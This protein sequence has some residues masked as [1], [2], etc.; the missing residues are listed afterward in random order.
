MADGDGVQEFSIGVL[1]RE[2]RVTTRTIRY[3]EDE[4]LL[5]PERRGQKRVYGPRERVRLRLILRGKRLGFSIAEIREILDM[6]QSEPGEAGQ[7]RHLI[8][9]I[10]ERRAA[11]ERQRADIDQTM[12]DMAEIEARCERALAAMAPAKRRAS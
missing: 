6:Y 3:Y 12:A 1:A 2:F 10:A 7:L 11:L 5:S 8:G 9:K 4:G